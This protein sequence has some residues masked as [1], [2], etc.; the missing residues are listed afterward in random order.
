MKAA[1]RT[2]SRLL[3]IGVQSLSSKV[4][5]P[6]NEIVDS[7]WLIFEMFLFSGDA[8]PGFDRHCVVWDAVSSSFLAC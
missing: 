8:G 5:Q 4:A 2:S 6:S 7:P 1:S 3:Q